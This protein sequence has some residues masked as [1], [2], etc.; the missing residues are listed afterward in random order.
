MVKVTLENLT[1]YFGDVR[2]VDHLSLEIKDSELIV[3]LGPSGCGKTTT[4]RM[5]AGLETPTEGK[6]YFDEEVVNDKPPQKRNVAMVFQ[7]YAL[8]PHMRVYD[9][10]AFP[11]KIK[12]LSKEEIDERVKG[13]AELLKISELLDRKPTQLSG[14]QQQRVALGRALVKEP[15]VLLLDE[16]LSNLDAKLRVLMRGE[17]KKLQKNLKITTIHVTHDQVEAMSIADRIAVINEGKLQQYGMPEEIYNKPANIFVAGFIGTPPMNFIELELA[18]EDG[19]ECAI[20]Y[21][22]KIPID[23]EVYGELIKYGNRVIVGVRPSNLI[24]SR[25]PS[26]WAIPAKIYII[27][28]LGEEMIIHVKVDGDIYKSVSTRKM[29]FKIDESVYISFDLSKAHWFSKKGGVIL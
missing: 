19:E 4:M 11:L 24:V 15:Q 20:A 17:I 23:K 2:A 1:K 5:I 14:G 3:L 21:N 16:P 12:K 26:K 9:N 27:E 13:I 22:H 6:I 8:Y 25:K 28:P 29:D 18:K 10:I 7:D